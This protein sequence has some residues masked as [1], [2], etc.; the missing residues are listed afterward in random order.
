MS[1]SKTSTK[2][3]GV[4]KTSSVSKPKNKNKKNGGLGMNGKRESAPVS[5][6]LN[7]TMSK[8]TF[9]SSSSSSGD[10]SVT[11]THREY[12]GDISGSAAFAL[13]SFPINPG[14]P[15]TFPWLSTLALNY[16][17]YRIRR[18]AFEFET[19]T[20][21]SV[22]GTLMMGVDYDA[23][24]PAPVSKVQLMN[25]HNST[26]SAVWQE[27]CLVLDASDIG[28]LGPKRYLRFGNLAANQDIKTYDVGNFFIASQGGGGGLVGEL[29]V[30]YQVELNTPQLDSSALAFALSGKV[31]TTPGGLTT[32]FNGPDFTGGGGGLPLSLSGAAFNIGR[33]GEYMIALRSVGTVF[34]GVPTLAVTAGSGNTVDDL[35]NIFDAAATSMLT[36]IRLRVVTPGTGMTA[37]FT[38]AATTIISIVSRVGAYSYDLN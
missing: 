25:Y 6:S 36:L 22:A 30:S 10:A 1:S 34:V 26:R 20:A 12:I 3:K 28:K 7:L 14:L 23:A 35:V 21:T 17:S 18:M 27:C 16:E 9:L 8:P 11:V 24:D 4:L 13:Q 15:G 37:N 32:P 29:Y 38:G 5:S 31:T 33:A 2:S 19:Q